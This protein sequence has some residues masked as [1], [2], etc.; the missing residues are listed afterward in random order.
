VT[1]SSPR[2]EPDLVASA[3][4]TERTTIGVALTRIPRHLGAVGD[5]HGEVREDEVGAPCSSEGLRVLGASG[6]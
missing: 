4:R 6:S 1:K 2:S 5:G 3:L